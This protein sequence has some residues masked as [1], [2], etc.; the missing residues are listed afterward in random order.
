MNTNLKPKALILKLQPD[1]ISMIQRSTFYDILE[2]TF[3]CFLERE[4]E[5][6]ELFFAVSFSRAALGPLGPG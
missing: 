6:K 4:R 5:Q 3:G 1:H 2:T